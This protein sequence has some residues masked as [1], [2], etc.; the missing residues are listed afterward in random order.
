MAVETTGDRFRRLFSQRAWERLQQE[1][2]LIIEKADLD[3]QMKAY[4]RVKEENRLLRA[5][6]AQLEARMAPKGQ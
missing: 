2:L 3:A 1:G 6:I 4:N 5:R